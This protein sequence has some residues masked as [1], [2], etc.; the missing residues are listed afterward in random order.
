MSWEEVEWSKVLTI[1]NGKNQKKVANP[2]G[3]YP[4][5]GSGGV[6]GYADDY[7]CSEN[8]VVIGRKGSINNPIYVKEKFWNVDTAF[9]LEADPDVLDSRFLFYFC[10]RFD[11][12]RLSTTVTIPSLTKT[13]LLAIKIPL[14]P[15]PIQKKIAEALEKADKLRQLR[16]EQLNKLDELLQSTFLDMF[17]DPVTNPKGWEVG[18]IEELV[19]NEKGA[20]KR[21]PFGGALKKEIFVEDGYLVYEQFHA[22]N[23]DFNFARY[24]ITEEKFNELKGFSVKAKDVIISCSG[25]NLGKLA[26]IPD[27]HRKGIINQALLKLSLDSSKMIPDLFTY[28]FTNK[29]FKDKFFGTQRGSGVPNFPPM[30]TFKRFQFIIPPISK[31]KEFLTRVSKIKSQTQL[32]KDSCDKT[33]DTFNSLMQKAFKGELEFK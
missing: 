11:F 12:E 17:G 5:Y 25:V 27:E 23:N 24:F 4:I 33:E 19:I 28:I 18:S 15:L 1:R 14:P 21:G 29:N 13:N 20:I 10:Q 26:I 16:Q 32:I 7:L 2:S 9:G 31:Q 6:M 22:L 3:Q 30:E 8:T